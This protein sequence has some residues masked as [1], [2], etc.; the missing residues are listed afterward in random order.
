MT[1]TVIFDLDGTLAL[2]DRR[3]DLAMASGKMDWQTF[4]DPQNI[5]F[6][7]PNVPVITSF[8][9]L[10][11]AGYKMVVFSGRDDISKKET[12]NWLKMHGVV[13]DIL[14][15]REHDDFTPD[16]I[17]KKSWL[18]EF[19]PDKS[20]VLCVFDDRDKVVNMWRREGLTCFQVAPGNF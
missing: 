7:E 8:Q 12:S 4:F 10:Q 18:D 9:A 16:D 3:R 6:D 17:L 19:F 1:K 13:P 15:M 5:Q 14:R 11:A 20:Q 2:I